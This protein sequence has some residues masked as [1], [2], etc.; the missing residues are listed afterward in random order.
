MP[1]E[2]SSSAIL[3]AIIFL[4][5]GYLNCGKL[6]VTLLTAR[7]MHVLSVSL[8]SLSSTRG[9]GCLIQYYVDRLQNAGSDSPL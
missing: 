3:T 2:K 7:E 6:I 4:V 1:V 5:S 8:H 9:N